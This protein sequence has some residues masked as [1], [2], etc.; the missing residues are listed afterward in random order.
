MRSPFARWRRGLLLRREVRGI[1]ADLQALAASVT[2]LVEAVEQRTALD[3]PPQPD[4]T[5]ARPGLEVE[6]VDSIRQHEMMDIELRLT[7]ARGE[8]PT[9]EEMLTEFLRR[10]AVE[11]DA[12]ERAAARSTP[13]ER[14]PRP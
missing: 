14:L 13:A 10:R 7:Q 9:E 1:R 6:Y 5:D 3:Y 11:E 8:P 4:L 12:E 2:R